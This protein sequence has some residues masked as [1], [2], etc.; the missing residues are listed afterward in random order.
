METKVLVVYASRY[1]STR[2]VADT[3]SAT[4][5]ERG[6]GVD[7]RPAHQVAALAEYGAVVLGAPLYLGAW[8]KDA[9]NF[10]LQHREILMKLP[11]AVFALGPLRDVEHEHDAARNMLDEALAKHPWL[12]PVEQRVFAGKF[13]PAKLHFVDRLVVSLPASPLHG[14]AA[15]DLRDWA[16]IR[17]W[18]I[19]LGAMLRPPLT[20]RRRRHAKRDADDRFHIWQ[21]GC[22]GRSRARYRR[23]TAGQRGARGHRDPLLAG[24]GTVTACWEA[25]RR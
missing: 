4:L 8:H 7:T 25:S 22:D 5:H 23:A 14:V 18:A 11:V 12:K 10:L 3:I 24:A 9:H 13:D 2:S 6:V 19:D 17:A 20:A 16:A 15:T 1:G 21:P